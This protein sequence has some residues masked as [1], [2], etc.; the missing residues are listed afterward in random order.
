MVSLSA[1]KTKS[2]QRFVPPSA[3]VRHRFLFLPIAALPGGDSAKP[4]DRVGFGGTGYVRYPYRHHYLLYY[5]SCM[6]KQH[7]PTNQPNKQ[8]SKQAANEYLLA[9]LVDKDFKSTPRTAPARCL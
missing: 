4:G 2:F 7:K 8:T 9:V 6:T 1:T 3:I 5:T